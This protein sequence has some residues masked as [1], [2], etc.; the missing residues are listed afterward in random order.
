MTFLAPERLL[1]LLPVVALVAVYAVMQRRRKHYAVRFT[2]MDLLDSVA[3]QRPGWRRHVT[4]GLAG[5]AALAIVLGLARPSAE[6]TVKSE[7]AVIMLAID[8]SI[9]MEAVD[10]DPSRLD[11]AKTE[12][13]AFVEELPDEYE[14][15]LVAFDG[16]ARVLSPATNDH[17]Q[18]IAAIAGLSTSRG[19]AGG[20][21]IEA[22]LSAIDV[23][24]ADDSTIVDAAVTAQATDTTNTDTV[25][26]TATIVML[27]DGTT[28]V[29]TPIDQAA[30]KAAAAGVP[31]STITYGS[32]EGTVTVQNQSI[33]VPPDTETMAAVAETTGGT[34]FVAASADELRAVYD[35]IESKVG[36]TTEERELTLGFVGAGLGALLLAAGA[37]FVWT[38]RF[39]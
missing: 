4:A 20:D 12:A 32:A 9:S 22:A 8:T 16:T 34:A 24:L 26:T 37:A 30:E 10:V 1:L 27:S 19:T 39:L 21:A 28:T 17:D 14:V 15:G 11:A 13:I 3:P 6:M 23:A 33:A 18:V 29:G 2:N 7:T 5:L 25:G 38:G 36:T 31:V 35:D